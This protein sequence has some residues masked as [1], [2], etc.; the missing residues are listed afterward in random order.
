M[1]GIIILHYARCSIGTWNNINTNLQNES[2]CGST[3]TTPYT[4][5]F[6]FLDAKFSSIHL[7]TSFQGATV[8]ALLLPLILYFSV[9]WM[10][11][12][13]LYIYLIHSKVLLVYY[14]L[15]DIQGLHVF[16]STKS[17]LTSWFNQ[18]SLHVLFITYIIFPYYYQYNTFPKCYSN[19]H[20]NNN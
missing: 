18:C 15:D 16:S 4:L 2:H 12:F 6:R 17:A 20:S 9:S 11:N 13:L 14:Y 3:F 8:A 7:F 5:L 10:P 19:H 1:C